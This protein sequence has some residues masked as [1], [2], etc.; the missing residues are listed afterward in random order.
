MR[1]GDYITLVDTIKRR[2]ALATLRQDKNAMLELRTL[3]VELSEKLH[4][5][6]EKFLTACEL[7]Y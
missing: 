5:D 1:K 2:R 6:R 4:V 7:K 3:A